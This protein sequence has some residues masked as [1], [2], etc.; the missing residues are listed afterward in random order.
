MCLTCLEYDLDRCLCCTHDKA[1]GKS[2]G[3]GALNNS[4]LKSCDATGVT[5][6][7][8]AGANTTYVLC[9]TRHLYKQVNNQMHTARKKSSVP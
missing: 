6:G 1:L 5:A 3:T 7:V 2:A 4:L 8:Y 9:L